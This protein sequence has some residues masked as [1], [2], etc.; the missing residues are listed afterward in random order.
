MEEVGI[1][2]FARRSRV[3]TKALRLFD[4]RRVRARSSLKELNDDRAHMKQYVSA[5]VG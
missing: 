4:K 3:S 2:E 5:G 1:G